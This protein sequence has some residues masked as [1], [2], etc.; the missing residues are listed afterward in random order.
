M[1]LNEGQ[2][3]D[4]ITTRAAHLPACAIILAGS[5]ARGEAEAVS[6]IDVVVLTH[7]A[8][9]FIQTGTFDGHPIE[10]LYMPLEMAQTAPVTKA[11]F[12]G[13]RPLWD[14]EGLGAAWL[15]EQEAVVGRP[16]GVSPTDMAYVRWDLR[17]ALDMLEYLAGGDLATF[18]YTRNH[19]VQELVDA[20]F[21]QERIWPPTVRRQMAALD[22]RFPALYPLVVRCLEARDA[23]EAVAA[24]RRTF[25]A[26]YGET[27]L[28]PLDL[29]P[30]LPMG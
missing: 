25:Q 29:A 19:W 10:I 7:A 26:V 8:G 2:L 1:R 5:F 15:L 22:Q 23:Y 28:A 17:Q 12:Q 27:P 9:R 14:P 20:L 18:R 11:T 3:V 13:A 24:C 16:R 4:V 6:D 30:I 21:A